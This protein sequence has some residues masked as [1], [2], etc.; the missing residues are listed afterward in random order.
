M[1]KIKVG[2]LINWQPNNGERY[3]VPDRYVG[4]CAKVLEIDTDD[5]DLHYRV[6]F[7]GDTQSW[8]ISPESTVKI[9]KKKSKPQ[10]NVGDRVIVQ[11]S[12]FSIYLGT[13]EATNTSRSDG[14]WLVQLDGD[15]YPNPYATREL[16]PT[17]PAVEEVVSKLLK[18][19]DDFQNRLKQIAEIVSA[20]E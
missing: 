3:S 15:S 10:L 19:V 18:D 9:K 4:K 20:W 7:V 16:I 17:T 13:I 6:T 5:K 2:E 14:K 8:W 1:S 11:I 12:P